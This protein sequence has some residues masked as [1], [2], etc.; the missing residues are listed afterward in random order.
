MLRLVALLTFIEFI[1]IGG[2][3]SC[4]VPPSPTPASSL[5]APDHRAL[6]AESWTAYRIRWAETNLQRQDKFKTSID[7]LWGWKWGQD[8]GGKWGILD[9]NLASELI[10][11][12]LQP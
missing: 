12:A 3:V 2:L 6:L 9:P 10:L 7:T 8:A 5:E 1:G 4:R 11:M